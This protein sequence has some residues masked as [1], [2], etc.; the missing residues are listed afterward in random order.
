MLNVHAHTFMPKHVMIS[1]RQSSANMTLEQNCHSEIITAAV[2]Y[3]S[4]V[5]SLA[6]SEPP[7]PHPSTDNEGIFSDEVDTPNI[8]FRDDLGDSSVFD[9]T[10][11]VFE[12][13]TPNTTFE[14]SESGPS[15]SPTVYSLDAE[16]SSSN[17]SI[18]SDHPLSDT[19]DS[20]SDADVNNA[21]NIL[22]EIR[23]RNVGRIVIGTLNINSLASKIDQLKIII[24]DYPHNSR[25]QT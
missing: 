9:I 25:N 14:N 17:S 5:T 1:G 11:C 20:D 3:T 23:V 15:D 7:V 13:D 4:E 24:R 10:P 16:E 18:A 21:R 12:V 8:T 6:I 22:R 2:V 19:G